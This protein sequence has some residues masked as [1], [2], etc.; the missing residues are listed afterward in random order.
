MCLLQICSAWEGVSHA[1]TN[2]SSTHGSVCLQVIFTAIPVL[3]A[4]IAITFLHEQ[5]FHALGWV[6]ASMIVAAGL[7]IA[8]STQQE[9]ALAAETITTTATAVT[10]DDSDVSGDGTGPSEAMSEGNL[11]STTAVAEEE[12]IEAV[13][14]GQSG[15]HSRG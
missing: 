9:A 1:V 12:Q 14:V 11:K 3:S 15:R 8:R 6:G 5:P 10:V 4:G 7:A 2:L 13:A